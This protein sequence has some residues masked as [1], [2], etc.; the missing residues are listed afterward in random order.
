MS[1]IG[2]K[3]VEIPDKVTVEFAEQVLTTKGPLGSLK[4][5]RAVLMTN[6]IVHF[7]GPFAP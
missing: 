7:A 1:R 5:E 3:P 2:K 6:F 4:R